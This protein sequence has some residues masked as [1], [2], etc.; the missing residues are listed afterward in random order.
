MPHLPISHLL[1][2]VLYI[3]LKSR[4]SIFCLQLGVNGCGLGG[5]LFLICTVPGILLATYG[6]SRVGNDLQH[7]VAS[8]ESGSVPGLLSLGFTEDYNRITTST[9]DTFSERSCRPS[10]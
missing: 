8:K 5:V 4:L 10:M 2:A 1:Y 9:L 7:V 3:Q 6:Y